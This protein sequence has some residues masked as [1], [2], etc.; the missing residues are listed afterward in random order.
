MIDILMKIHAKIITIAIENR[1]PYCFIIIL[2]VKK[3][4]YP[5]F[6]IRCCFQLMTTHEWSSYYKVHEVNTVKNEHRSS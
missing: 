6:L 3:F 2:N 4:R 1:K 5:Y